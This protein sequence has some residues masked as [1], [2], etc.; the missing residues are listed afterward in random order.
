M[1]KYIFI[2]GGV[3]SGGGK[4][5]AAASTAF[6]LK[7]R[8][9]KVNLIKF[10]PY[11]SVNAGLLAPREHGEV[12]LTADGGELDLDAGHYERIGGVDM[13]K[14]HICTAGTLY[15]ELIEEQEEGK[16]LG[17]TVQVV[18]HITDKIQKRLIKFGKDYDIVI[19][20]I[21]GTIG[22][23][24]SYAFYEAIR[25]FKSKHD[26]IVV[27]V[28][29]IL[30]LETIQE[31]K[32]KPL[33]N[34]VRSLNQQGLQADVILCRTTKKIPNNII[35]KIGS[36]TGVSVNNIFAAPD[37]ETIYQVP[38]ELYSQNFDDLIADLLN[39]KRSA[40]RIQKYREAVNKY[41]DNNLSSVIIGVFGKYSSNA[42]EA[43][44][45]L[46]EALIHAGL[47]N[48][49]KVNIQWITAE[50]L[51]NGV[52][53]AEKFKGL[54][55]I[56]VPG[57]FDSRG[58]EGKIKAIKYA[59]ENKIPFLG[60][61]LGLQCAVIEYAR[62]ICKLSEANSTEFDKNTP[63]PVVNFVE[64]QEKITKKS[65]T[66]R[67]GSY[68]CEL[69]KDTLA[70]ELYDKKKLISERH[71]HRYEVNNKYISILKEKNLTISGINPESNLVE[72]IELDGHPF[73]I[74][75][76]SH[77]EFRSRLMEP[78]PLFKGLVAA[79]KALKG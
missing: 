48:N 41:V 46:K 12:F 31:F 33:Q 62:N 51:E 23:A 60:I 38:I 79:A 61:C 4:G 32:T 34:A 53:V 37:V 26:C 15:K 18:P 11:L 69:S 24:E 9:Y 13:T 20:E 21:G 29:P 27:M 68:D 70:Y 6:L 65:S 44:L 35:D 74:A 58:V 78:A 39:L 77:P 30:W 36:M 5:V 42:V 3:L 72:M 73:F 17:Q 14:E 16:Y 2:C 45:S 25:Q 75:T 47:S 71:R 7:C 64:G 54:D 56:I 28:A 57:G 50:D 76:Q 8:G 1:A 43:Y 10:D 19:T 63:H 49:C 67:L 55:G 40:C 66:M 22:D 59:R 52:S